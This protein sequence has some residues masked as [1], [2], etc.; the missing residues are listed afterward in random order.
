LDTTPAVGLEVMVDTEDCFS[1]IEI[2]SEIGLLV[3]VTL[4][5]ILAE[6]KVI[7]SR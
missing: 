5:V 4:D 6:K 1:K 7:D 3:L 2:R